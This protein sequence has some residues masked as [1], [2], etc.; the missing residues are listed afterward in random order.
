MPSTDLVKGPNEATQEEGKGEA[1]QVPVAGTGENDPGETGS[2]SLEGQTQ[3]QVAFRGR[4]W[5]Y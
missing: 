2:D 1:N 5:T 3:E 4:G